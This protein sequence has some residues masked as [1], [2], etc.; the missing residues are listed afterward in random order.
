MEKKKQYI[1]NEIFLIYSIGFVGYGLLEIVWR[2]FTHWTMSLTGG[3]CFLTIY[4]IEKH[5]G[6]YPLWKKCVLGAVVITTIEFLV[7]V[8]VNLILGWNV[9]DYSGI[10]LNLFGQV[11]LLYTML[12]FFLCIPLVKLSNLLYR[13]F[14]LESHTRE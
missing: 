5:L 3:F 12:W 8:S 4:F 11:C 7:G 10:P 2:G 14:F 9:W 6:F 1:L 13:K